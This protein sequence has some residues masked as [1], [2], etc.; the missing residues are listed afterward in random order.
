MKA[1][2]NRLPWTTVLCGSVLLLLST[3]SYGKPFSTFRARHK[4]S[5]ALDLYISDSQLLHTLDTLVVTD[6][7]N[8]LKDSDDEDKPMNENC[9]RLL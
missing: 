1:N 7:K 4:F 9:A 5:D 8:T 6:S 3:T 2:I